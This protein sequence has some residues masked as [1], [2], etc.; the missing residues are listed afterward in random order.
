MPDFV[1]PDYPLARFL[2]ERGLGLIYLVA[3][4]V[5][6]RQFPALCGERGLEPAPRHLARRRFRD[7]PTLFH[8][9]Y[10]DRRLTMASWTGAIVALLIVVGVVEQ[11]PLPLTMLAWV[12]LWALYLSIV[13]IGGTFYG[14]GWETLL[15]E[16]GSL[17][18]FLGNDAVAPAWPILLAFR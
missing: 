7:A 8:W 18:I 16:A 4:V 15:L 14:F 12:L 11:A 13:N 2:I 1:A 17:A 6:A 9:G 3:F 10:S 5:A